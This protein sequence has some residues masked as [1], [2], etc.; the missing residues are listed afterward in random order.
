MRPRSSAKRNRIVCTR[1][2]Y[3]HCPMLL[4]LRAWWY[5]R[6]FGKAE[7]MPRDVREYTIRRYMLPALA[8][9]K[10]EEDRQKFAAWMVRTVLDLPTDQISEELRDEVIR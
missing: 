9:Q 3:Y 10:T 4:A 7:R 5:A 1:R 6:G 8:A 2:I